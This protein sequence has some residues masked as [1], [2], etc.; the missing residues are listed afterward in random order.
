MDHA[1]FSAKLEPFLLMSKSVKGAAAAKLIQDA[2]AAPGVFVFSELL[3]LPNIQELGKSEQHQKFLSLLQLF[4]FKTY[5]DYLQHKDVLPPLNQAQIIKLK[6]LTIVSLAAERRILPYADLLKALDIS[7]VRELEDLI[8]DAIYLDLL[9]GKLDQKEEQLEVTYTAG[10]DLEPGK[11]EQ[12]LAALKGWATTTSAVLTT[13]DAKINSIAADTAAQKLNQQ[14]HERILQAH[15]KEVFEKQKEKSMGGGMASRRAAFQ[16]GDRENMMDVDEPDNKG[17]NRNTNAAPEAPYPSTPSS[18]RPPTMAEIIEVVAINSPPIEPLRI[19]SQSEPMPGPSSS[20]TQPR[21]QSP[22]RA[23][24]TYA[25]T[26]EAIANFKPTSQQVISGIAPHVFDERRRRRS[27]RRVSYP[28]WYGPDANAGKR[29]SPLRGATVIS[30]DEHSIYLEQ[31]DPQRCSTTSIAPPEETAK[32]EALGP[33]GHAAEQIDAGINSHSPSVK[34]SKSGRR[35]FRV[36]THLLRTLIVKLKIATTL[37]PS[38]K[39]T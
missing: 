2:T 32:S 14:E 20:D 28:R 7:S 17:K 37:H 1:N 24:K 35:Y 8:I 19:A 36:D 12:V 27:Q 18:D 5:Q 38:I 6:H 22:R 16:M 29:P 10:R 34:I 39:P 21:P 33:E 13:L 15:L 11:L 3:E 26:A 25:T 4:A 30:W 31:S 9:Q 23:A